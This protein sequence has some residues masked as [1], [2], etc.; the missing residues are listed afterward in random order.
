MESLLVRKFGC[1]QDERVLTLTD[2]FAVPDLP[3]PGKM[4]TATV[5]VKTEPEIQMET[6]RVAIERA[7]PRGDGQG[8]RVEEGEVS[9]TET[10][11]EA[12]FSQRTWKHQG[13]LMWEK[14][15]KLGIKKTVWNNTHERFQ[16]EVQLRYSKEYSDD[17]RKWKQL[18]LVWDYFCK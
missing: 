13:D 6:A 12:Y 9:E 14:G 10:V 17:W 8:I 16:K 1:L 18:S 4:A 5:I 3:F 15:S 2:G 7:T 11:T